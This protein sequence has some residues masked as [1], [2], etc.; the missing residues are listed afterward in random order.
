MNFKGWTTLMIAAGCG[1]DLVVKCL[2]QSR[3]SQYLEEVEEIWSSLQLAT[4]KGY[5]ETVRVLLEF[6]KKN[7]GSHYQWLLSAVVSVENSKE[8]PDIVNLLEEYG[9]TFAPP[10]QETD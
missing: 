1:H 8:N 7:I 4:Q 3:T 2:L 5:V 9:A 10:A 6:S